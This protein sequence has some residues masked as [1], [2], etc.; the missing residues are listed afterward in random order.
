MMNG[1]QK[2]FL[3]FIFL[4]IVSILGCSQSDRKQLEKAAKTAAAETE[5]KA[6][7]EAAKLAKE[8]EKKMGTEAAKVFATLSAKQP[9]DAIIRRAKSWVDE[10][11]PYN[12]KNYHDGYRT[13][14]SGFVSYSWQLVKD[15]KP[16]SPDTV[17]LGSNYGV[18]IH[19]SELQAGDIINNKRPGNTGHV[20][21]FVKWVDENYTSFLAYEENGGKGKAVQTTLTLKKTGDSYTIIEYDRNAPGPYYAQTIKANP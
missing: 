7:T 17:A 11:I 6:K 15:G 16:V 2:G 21:I 3:A 1:F 8:A 5:K 9:R 19:F 4:L 12:Q 20:V 18:D 14:C 10:E 13:D